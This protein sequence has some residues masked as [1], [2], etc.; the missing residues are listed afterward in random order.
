MREA[1][2]KQYPDYSI[3]EV[4]A[5]GNDAWFADEVPPG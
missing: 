2:V 5:A 3:I 4:F 1:I